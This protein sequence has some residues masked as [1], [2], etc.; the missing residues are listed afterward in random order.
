[1]DEASGARETDRQVGWLISL[2]GAV[3]VAVR[4]ATGFEHAA[5]YATWWIVGG[6]IMAVVVLC[7][8]A[9]G[10]VLPFGV[11]RAC[12]IGIPVLGCLLWATAFLAYQGDPAQAQLSWVWTLEPVVASFL[13]LCVRPLAATA[14]TIV[15]ALLPAASALVFLGEVPQILVQATP[16]HLSNIGFVAIFVGIRAR[17]NRLRE[18][19]RRAQEQDVM[20]A[21]AITE[22]RRQ[23][24]LG[25]LVHDEVLSVLSAARSFDGEPPAPLRAEARHALALIEEPTPAGPAG[26]LGSDEALAAMT[27]ALRRID[28]A[29][30]LQT[31]AGAGSVPSAA[32]EAVTLAAAEAMRNSV[33]H[34][35]PD[36]A[37]RLEARVCAGTIE[38]AVRDEGLGFDPALV[39]PRR[40]GV[41]QSI[42]ARM[43]ELDG[44]DARIATAPGGGTEVVLTWRG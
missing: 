33:R 21:R 40:L 4:A 14:L 2:G 27:A 8:A 24:Q 31:V 12:W 30:S 26:L 15:S 25:R 37:R 18:S 17:L 34:A 5:A 13:V 6:A 28:P 41:R 32:V 20:R 39:D 23:A 22:A 29:C 38:V 1:V 42:L 10:R 35:G 11:L 43:A 19:E 7:L 9:L 36:G 44:G 16:V 3:L